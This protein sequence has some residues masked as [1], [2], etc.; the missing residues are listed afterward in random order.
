M[1]FYALSNSILHLRLCVC[2][3]RCAIMSG[4]MKLC[5]TG[6]QM[7]EEDVRSFGAWGQEFVSHLMWVLVSGIQTPALATEH[8][9]LKT[10]DPSLQCHF[11]AKNPFLAATPRFFSFVQLTFPNHSS[12]TPVSAQDFRLS[13]LP[14]QH[15]LV[16]NDSRIL[17]CSQKVT[18]AGV[19]KSVSVYPNSRFSAKLQN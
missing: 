15:W 5:D 14:W 16:G 13:I 9:E 2:V 3:C 17:P 19:R 10:A 12:K 1:K 4:W 6:P 7:Q 8:Q 11:Q 18:E